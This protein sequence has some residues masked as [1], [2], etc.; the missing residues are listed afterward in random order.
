MPNSSIAV[1]G[2]Q[3]A[4]SRHS[5]SSFS[6]E[7]PRVVIEA[8]EY[9]M[10]PL[11]EPIAPNHRYAEPQMAASMAKTHPMAPTSPAVG[12]TG[13]RI[14]LPWFLAA[15]LT[16]CDPQVSVTT[17]RACA[18]MVRAIRLRPQI[19]LDPHACPRDNP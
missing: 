18:A 13:Y 3:C 19:Q 2:F 16:R 15:A 1:G 17:P 12:A 14:T 9:N 8:T 7:A 10:A 11:V 6:P 4:T 5:G